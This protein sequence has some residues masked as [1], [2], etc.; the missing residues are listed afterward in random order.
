M[1]IDA[2]AQITGLILAGGL[3]S[4]MGGRDKGLQ[5][6]AGRPL[7]AHVIDRLAPQVD[8]LVINANR[9]EDAYRTFGYPVIPDDIEGF[10]GP[11]A[12]LSAGLKACKT[13][14]LATAPCDSPFIPPDLVARLKEGLE[15]AGAMI[16][17]AR[18]SDGLQ[19]VFAL[20]RRDVLPDLESF[21]SEGG[22]GIQAWLHRLP[23]ATIDFENAA[24]FANINTPE[25]LAASR[26]G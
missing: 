9:N 2:P 11:L 26:H 24:A 8:A 22:R 19:P 14:F 1:P 15:R 25:E 6:L 12:G 16:A 10:I 20:M 3:G 23:L 7:V 21:L 13:P 17:V 5:L 18:T 4:R